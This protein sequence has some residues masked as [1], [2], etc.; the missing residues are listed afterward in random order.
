MPALHH[1]QALMHASGTYGVIKPA[2]NPFRDPHAKPRWAE[3][4]RL[5]GD[6][7]AILFE[8]LRRRLAG[9][10]G[11]QEELF[12]AGPEDGWLARYKTGEQL[13]FS[14]HILPGALEASLEVEAPLRD[15]VLASP[16]VA[17][18]IKEALRRAALAPRGKVRLRL[19]SAALVRSFARLVLMKSRFD[20]R[21]QG[22]GQC[23]AVTPPR[24]R[25]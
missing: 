8:D 14:A 6:R 20:N 23:R 4:T 1:G 22:G 3:L 18:G 24:N 25:Q 21:R 11:V 10:E 17:A 19:S 15:R 2:E 9:I 16:G 13:L 5:A 7:A 12:Y